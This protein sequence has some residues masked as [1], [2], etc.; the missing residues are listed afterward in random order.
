MGRTLWRSIA[1]QLR[2]KRKGKVG[3]IWFVDY[4]RV[5][6]KWCYL[7]RGIDEDGN[8]VDVRLSKKRDLEAAKAFFAQAH[9][10]VEDIPNGL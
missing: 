4:V 6:G 9:E 3:K 7:Y 5:K 8:L 10:L 1:E 2:A